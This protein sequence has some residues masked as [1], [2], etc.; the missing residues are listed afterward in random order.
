MSSLISRRMYTTSPPDLNCDDI[1]DTNFEV[2]GSDPHGFDADNDGIGC[3]SGDGGI[4]D[5]DDDDDDDD[6]GGGD[7]DPDPG[8]CDGGGDGGGNGDGGAGEGS[9]TT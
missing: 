8:N 4:P 9:E 3:E 5:D 1:D 2:V 7:P 6:D